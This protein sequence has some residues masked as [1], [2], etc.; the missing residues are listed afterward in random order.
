VKLRL[1]LDELKRRHVV[2][3]TGFYLVA[4]WVLIQVADTVFPA[5]G[6]AWEPHVRTVVL[7]CAAGLPVTLLLGWFFDLTPR[8]VVRTLPLDIQPDGL[9]AAAPP[10]TAQVSRAF[11]FVGLGIVVALVGFAAISNYVPHGA[12]EAVESVA[13]LPF[14]GV[15]DEYAYLAD[16]LAEELRTRLAQI[17]ALHVAGRTLPEASGTAD[18][19]VREVGRLMQV[20]AVIDGT[21]RKFGDSLRVTVNLT[22]SNTGRLLWSENFRASTSDLFAVQE[23]IAGKVMDRLRVRLAGS[24]AVQDYALRSGE[25]FDLFL[26]ASASL[27][28]RTDADLRAALTFYEQATHVDPT[29]DRAYAGL[30]KT[31]AVLPAFGDFPVSEALRKGSQAAAKAIELNP[32]LGEAYAALGQ[33]AQNFQW[34]MATAL[35]SYRRAVRFSPSDPTAHQWYAE[36]LMLT[37]ELDAAAAEIE[38]ALELDPLSPAA[39]NVRAYQQLLAGQTE[40]SIRSLQQ[41]VRANDGFALGHMFLGFA[42]LYVKDWSTATDALAT[43]APQLGPDLGTIIAA[44][45]GQGSAEAAVEAIMRLEARWS[46]SY[47][48]LLYMAVGAPDHAIRTLERGFKAGVDANFPYVLVH[49]IFKPISSDPRYKAIIEEIGLTPA[50]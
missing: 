18:S 30:A 42:A 23:E 27:H 25:G 15:G 47:V 21:I 33:I 46:P 40:R 39:L 44:A 9:P 34:D 13:V 29:F 45:S 50:R 26:K 4:A 35:R 7:I 43:G 22:A 14:R 2:R 12:S 38:Q 20:E 19:D 32:Q 48:A 49:P 28:E 8:G 31:Y 1:F 41:L 3:V 37:G 11:G 16:G 5:F 24:Q 17:P 10:R 36:A 6:P